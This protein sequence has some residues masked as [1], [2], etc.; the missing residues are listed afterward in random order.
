MANEKILLIFSDQAMLDV[1]S[2]AVL[3]PN[4]YQASSCKDQEQA[5]KQCKIFQPD[6]IV[7]GGQEDDCLQQAQ[8]IHDQYPAIPMVLIANSGAPELLLKAMRAGVIEYLS[9][10][11]PTKDV[12]AAVQRALKQRA[13]MKN[14]ALLE[15]RRN[16]QALEQQVSEMEAL[17]RVGRS[18]TSS[19]DLDSVLM[20]AVEAV[21][22]L[23]GAEEGNL[24]LPDPQTGE[25]Y[26]RAA[27]NL[28]DEFVQTFRLPVEDTLAGEV[29]R[30]GEPVLFTSDQLQKIKTAFFVHSLLYVP[31]RSHGEIIG[32]MGVHNRESNRSFSKRHVTI[33]EAIA[34]FA[35]IAIENA[36][37]YTS[38]EIERRKLNTIITK[39]VDGVIVTDHERRLVF[40]NPTARQAFGV[41]INSVAG[42]HVNDVV[43]H[44]ELL[45][46]YKLNES[47]FPC[48]RELTLDDGR[49]LNAQATA[50]PEVGLAITLQDI[51][52]LKELD[53]IKSEFVSTVSHDLRS[54]LTAIMGYVE[55]LDR[56]GP[57]NNTQK[58]FVQRVHASVLS[59]TSLI[60]ELLDL[61]RIEAGFDS[62]K[63]HLA[64][65][66]MI[67]LAIE[68][69]RELVDAKGQL[70]MLEV[71]PD[72]PEV[73]ASPIRLQ[74]VLGN[75]IGNAVKYTQAG[76]WVK[77]EAHAEAQQ[78]IIQV[79]D[80]G[81]GIP[82]H[83]Q[84]YVFD[85]FYRASNTDE[86][87]GTGLGL[88]IVKSIVENQQ[89]R[90]WVD[91]TPGHGST[92]TAVLPLSTSPLLHKANDT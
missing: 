56:V 29:F 6:A 39:V 13:A 16:T 34:D 53:R 27:K 25:L 47:Q 49:V 82:I 83:E 92:F 88:A 86:T 14:W 43:T 81:P 15:S 8:A 66:V 76:G 91:S 62:E 61:G 78:L 40:M 19:L 89:G 12:L 5:L 70:L 84:P 46:I 58:E 80:N 59:I 38:T 36:R 87:T 2:R 37:L 9:P 68:E 75:L 7:I 85:K 71:A 35:A 45:H 11:V 41:S 69:L 73:Y 65:D 23:T 48:R 60:N 67:Q 20:T 79:S 30:S 57:L 24:L 32:V 77:I 42:R 10:P 31:L 51:T 33:A 54:P 52:Q 55:L 74:Q 21:V 18:V 64:L 1:L 3:I 22:E 90:V 4:N 17:E 28:G 63:E 44:K 72:L 26:V 50:I